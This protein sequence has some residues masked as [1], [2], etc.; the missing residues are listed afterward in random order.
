MLALCA[1]L[2][3]LVSGEEVFKEHDRHLGPARDIV[4]LMFPLDIIVSSIAE[5]PMLAVEV[6][7]N[8]GEGWAIGVQPA[9][10][11]YAPGSTLSD[12]H[13][14][15]LGLVLSGHWYEKRALAGGFVTLQ[16]G[17]IEAFVGDE[18][19]RTVGA[20]AIFGY[21]LSWDDG[22]EVSIGLGFG[23]W[24]RMGVVGG[25]FTLPEILSWRLGVGW[26]W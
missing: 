12:A 21:A 10:V 18:F 17:D 6:R 4:I 23:Y 8:L 11:Y 13:G 19:G 25:G 7:K 22:A 16:V 24:H 15:G 14:G 20:A 5:K 9:V 2:G 1:T 26:G 3:T